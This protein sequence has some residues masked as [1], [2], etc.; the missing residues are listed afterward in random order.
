MPPQTQGSAE[1]DPN[2]PKW[3][4]SKGRDDGNGGDKGSIEQTN[5]RRRPK[6]DENTMANPDK[7]LEALFESMTKKVRLRFRHK[8]TPPQ[9]YAV[10]PS[11][12]QQYHR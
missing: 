6:L 4:P 3:E 11:A 7:C 8:I 10:L 1:A 2:H 5:K 9:Q 12:S